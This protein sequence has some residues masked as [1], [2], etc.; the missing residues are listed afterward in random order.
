MPYALDKLKKIAKGTDKVER[1]GVI[2]KAKDPNAKPEYKIFECVPENPKETKAHFKWWGS[3]QERGGYVPK[4]GADGK[5]HLD[6]EKIMLDKDYPIE[7]DWHTH[8]PT[9]DAW[10]SGYDAETS[11]HND[12]PGVVIRY[13][14]RPTRGK[15]E[16]DYTI[17]ITD[18]DGKA[19]EYHPH[20]AMGKQ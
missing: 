17:W 11:K 5:I 13:V 12:V 2:L 10:P 16:D 18:T 3:D 4:P 14:G 8:P 20:T 7:F 6:D 1:F 19:Y 15:I 9:G